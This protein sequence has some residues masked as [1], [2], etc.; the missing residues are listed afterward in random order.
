MKANVIE[1]LGKSVRHS[2]GRRVKLNLRLFRKV[3]APASQRRPP[4]L[5]ALL[6][7]LFCRHAFRERC[8][9]GR[10]PLNNVD[11]VKFGIFCE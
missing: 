7:L 11:V 8:V 2:G 9:A 1:N 10:F 4:L 6:S 5:L 3:S